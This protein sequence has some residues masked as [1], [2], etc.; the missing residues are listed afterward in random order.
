MVKFFSW[1]LAICFAVLILSSIAITHFD[2][3]VALVF[4]KISLFTGLISSIGLIITLVIERIKDKKE[5][6]DDFSKY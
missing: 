1:I 2:E 5:E 3:N 6:K 4:V